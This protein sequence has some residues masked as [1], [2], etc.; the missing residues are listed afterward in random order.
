[1]KICDN[2]ARLKFREVPGGMAVPGIPAR[3]IAII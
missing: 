2:R 3:M 1:V